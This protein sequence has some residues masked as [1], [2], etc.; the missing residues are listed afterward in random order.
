MVQVEGREV[1]HAPHG[2]RQVADLAGDLQLQPPGVLARRD[3]VLKANIEE[4]R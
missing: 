3:V 4:N 2:G 1:G